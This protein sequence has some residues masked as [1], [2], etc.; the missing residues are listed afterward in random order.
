MGVSLGLNVVLIIVGGLMD[1]FSATIVVVPLVVP[2]AAHF[3]VDPVHLES[4]SW[5]MR[6]GLPDAASRKNSFLPHTGSTNRSSNWRDV[7][8]VRHSLVGVLLITYVPWLTTDSRMAAPLT[9]E[10]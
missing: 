6:N 10:L 7:T 2:I 9:A 1:I 5:L 3:N 8:D 4:S